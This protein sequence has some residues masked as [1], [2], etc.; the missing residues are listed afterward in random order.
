MVDSVVYL[1]AGPV[2]SKRR[3]W[4]LY[5][6]GLSRMLG[7]RALPSLDRCYLMRRTDSIAAAAQQLAIA[8]Q[9]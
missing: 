9:G 8:Q 2:S 5:R 1:P 7:R 4:E 3:Y 6:K